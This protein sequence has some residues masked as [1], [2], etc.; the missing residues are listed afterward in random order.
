[1]ILLIDN[2]DSFTFNIYQYFM[3]IGMDVIVKKHNHIS[4]QLIK[5]I[6]P[7]HLVISPGPGNPNEFQKT[8]KVILYF[9]KKIPILGICLG[10]QA[11]GQVFGSTIIKANHIMHGKTSLVYHK[12]KGIFKKLKSPLRMMRYH[13]LIIDKNTIPDCFELTAWTILKKNNLK[14]Y[15]VMGIRHRNYFVEGVQFHPESILSEYGHNLFI[16]FIK[17]KY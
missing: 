6:K 15:E 17:Y 3:E 1:M 7:T 11:I 8:L 10:H 4:I 2:Q 9:F 12:Q 5:S 16:N 13:S 14:K